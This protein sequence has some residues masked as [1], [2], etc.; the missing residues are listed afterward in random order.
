MAEWKYANAMHTALIH[1][2][3]KYKIAKYGSSPTY[4]L[5]D[6]SSGEAKSI[7]WSDDVNELK[8]KIEGMSLGYS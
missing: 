1:K 5:W 6:I 4:G 2:S 7:Q 3:G 8:S